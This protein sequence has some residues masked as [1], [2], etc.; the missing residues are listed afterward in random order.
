M[1]IPGEEYKA[2]VHFSNE[3]GVRAQCKDCH[4]NEYDTV[5]YVKA[6]MGGVKDIWSELTGKI[7]TKEKYEEHRLKMAKSVWDTMA[8]NNSATCRKCHSYETM[9][10]SKMSANAVAQ[11]KPAAAK[12]QSCI[13]CH[14][15]IAHQ[16][17]KAKS[18]AKLLSTVET[19]QTVYTTAIS[20]LH[21]TSELEKSRAKLLPLTKVKLLEK[22][23]TAYLIQIDGWKEGRKKVLYAEKGL[24]IASATLRGIKDLISTNQTYHD[25]VTRNDWESQS[26]KAWVQ[27]I[28][29]ISSLDH[30]FENL[31]FEYDSKCG[32]C[33][34]KV[35]EG[36]F[37]ANDWPAQFKGM[38]RQAK[39]SKDDSQKLLKYLQYHSSDFTKH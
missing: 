34:T 3:H 4:I 1:E 38:A 20:T 16:L 27:D 37:N 17:P 5:D 22:S 19:N 15:G 30:E 25:E 24:R 39:L 18:D 12:D 10:W 36:H 29:V 28:N 8:A 35:E 23:G 14:K 32:A 13:N 33:H 6:K 2:T 26:M 31:A 7:D 11:M 21:N 9:D